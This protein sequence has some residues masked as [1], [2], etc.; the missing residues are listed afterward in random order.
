M[1][2]AFRKFYTNK[3]WLSLALFSPGQRSLLWLPDIQGIIQL[4]CEFI[5]NKINNYKATEQIISATLFKDFQTSH[6]GYF[7]RHSW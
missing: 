7:A 1:D 4:L 6:F 5:N 2:Y 3:N